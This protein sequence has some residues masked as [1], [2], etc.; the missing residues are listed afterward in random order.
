[1]AISDF[2]T[3]SID[4]PIM[5]TNDAG[6]IQGRQSPPFPTYRKRAWN[7]DAALR[8]AYCFVIDDGTDCWGYSSMSVLLDSRGF[9]HLETPNQSLWT[10][11][12]S[13]PMIMHLEGRGC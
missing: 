2:R 8:P 12:A 7:A 9:P 10:P 4:R 3:A 6:P 11:M 5:V 13:P 1:M